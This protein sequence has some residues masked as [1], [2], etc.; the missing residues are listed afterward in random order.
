MA[1]SCRSNQLWPDTSHQKNHSLHADTG[2]SHGDN[3]SH[4]SAARAA[5]AFGSS[6]EGEAVL[7]PS[8]RPPE[9]GMEA[10]VGGG[11]VVVEGAEP[12][13]RPGLLNVSPE[14]EEPLPKQL[15]MAQG[16]SLVMNARGLPDVSQCQDVYL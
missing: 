15:P 1:R 2:R 3:E 16:V 7:D 9:V 11:W 12:R 4:T 5:A 13:V 8:V 6:P 14:E 10:L